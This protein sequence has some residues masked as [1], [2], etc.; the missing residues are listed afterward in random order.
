MTRPIG[1][2]FEYKGVQLKVVKRGGCEG[3]YFL[4]YNCRVLD[5]RIPGY[6]MGQ[7]RSDNQSVIFVKTSQEQIKSESLKLFVHKKKITLNFD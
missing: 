4:H 7:N 2:V 3:C 5:R 1:D 6:C